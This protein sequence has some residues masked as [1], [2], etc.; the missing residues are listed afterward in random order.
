MNDV[1][2][3][4]IQLGIHNKY[5]RV[6]LCSDGTIIQNIRQFKGIIIA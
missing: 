1:T 6:I 2:Y 3:H 4:T 5:V